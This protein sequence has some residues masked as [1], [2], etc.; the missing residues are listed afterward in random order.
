ML[1]FALEA[2]NFFDVLMWLA[3]SVVSAV[4]TMV[5]ILAIE[6]VRSR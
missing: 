2:F 1:F 5:L 4:L 6:S 3:R